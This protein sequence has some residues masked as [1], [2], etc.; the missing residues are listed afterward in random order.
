MNLQ[1]KISYCRKKAGLS[2]EALAEKM[3]VSRQAISKWETGDAVPEV[4]KLKLLASVFGV[5]A[6]WLLSDD[7]P[8][9]LNTSPEQK[10][11][12]SRPVRQNN[13]SHYFNRYGWVIGILPIVIGIILSVQGAI[14]LTASNFML[15]SFNNNVSNMQNEFQN[16]FPMPG[17]PQNDIFGSSITDS[18]SNLAAIPNSI[19]A[20]MLGLG[21]AF[22]IAGIIVTVILKKRSKKL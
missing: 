12:Q 2:Q 19:A 14:F 21:I 8:P 1:E 5:T 15:N 18:A 6:D 22:I 11:A 16:Y 10:D 9:N 20:I 13:F 17:F 3:D 4:G 7:D